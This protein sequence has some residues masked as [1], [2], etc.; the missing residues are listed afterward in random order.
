MHGKRKIAVDQ[1]LYFTTASILCIFMSPYISLISQSFSRCFNFVGRG[2]ALVLVL[3][4]LV[5]VLVY[6]GL[7]LITTM[8]NQNWEETTVNTVLLLTL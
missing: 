1:A 3:N 4:L 6:K 5:L 8:S 2:Q 7:V